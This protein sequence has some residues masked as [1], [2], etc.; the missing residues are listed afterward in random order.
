[1][2]IGP[3]QDHY[4]TSDAPYGLVIFFIGEAKGESRCF[5]SVVGEAGTVESA[6]SDSRSEGGR[7]SGS[8]TGQS[9]STVAW[10]SR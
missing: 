8:G 4:N 10:A 3:R 1:M 9:W 6:S 5:S 2:Y 7:V